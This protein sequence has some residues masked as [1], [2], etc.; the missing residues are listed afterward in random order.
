MQTMYVPI[1]KGEGL[2]EYEEG[3]QESVHPGIGRL[4]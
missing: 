1:L 3:G 2:L 4:P